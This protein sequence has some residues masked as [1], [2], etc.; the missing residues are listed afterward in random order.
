MRF[1][2][3]REPSFDPEFTGLL[4]RW[5]LWRPAVNSRAEWL[6]HILERDLRENLAA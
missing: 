6:A 5:P 2:L 3:F 4:I 1:E